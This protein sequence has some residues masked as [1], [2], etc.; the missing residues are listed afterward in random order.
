MYNWGRGT[1]LKS[2]GGSVI[3]LLYSLGK[4]N[5]CKAVRTRIIS[6]KF[7]IISKITR[8]FSIVI[9]F[10]E[11]EIFISYDIF[12]LTCTSLRNKFA[13]LGWRAIR[14]VLLQVGISSATTGNRFFFSS[15]I[16]NSI[17]WCFCIVHVR[18]SSIMNA[19]FAFKYHVL[20]FDDS[21]V[22]TTNVL[23]IF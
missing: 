8:V 14:F 3:I 10:Y 20:F 13:G 5:F 9:S 23:M 7:S 16:L 4:R 2:F 22:R 1:L 6:L 19:R 11:F 15:M 18:R 21:F 12:H 17:S